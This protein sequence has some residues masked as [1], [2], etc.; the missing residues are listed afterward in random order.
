MRPPGHP[1]LRRGATLTLEIGCK[2]KGH[3][4]I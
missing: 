2:E 1:D 4:Q 3:G